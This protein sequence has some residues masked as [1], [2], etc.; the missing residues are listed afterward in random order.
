MRLDQNYTGVPPLV[1]R[2]L[3]S[4]AAWPTSSRTRT[5]SRS[6]FAF[7]ATSD[8]DL[9]DCL[10]EPPA[11]NC[12]GFF[13]VGSCMM[14][15]APGA[16]SEQ[17][18]E[19]IVNDQVGRSH[20][21]G[22]LATVDGR[23]RRKPDRS[24]A[25]EGDV[26]GR[27][28]RRD[29]SRR[30]RSRA[31]SRRSRPKTSPP[32]SGRSSGTVNSDCAAPAIETAG[33]TL[34]WRLQCRGQLDIDATGRVHLRQPASLH[35]GHHVEGQDGG[36]ADQ[37]REDRHRGRARRRLHAVR[38]RAAIRRCRD[39]GRLRSAAWCRRRSGRGRPAGSP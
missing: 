23:R 16:G 1:A 32:P 9:E 6:T 15:E 13:F 26:D 22:L 17:A 2:R 5:P 25:M 34:K 35:G 30:R 8:P 7:S 36:R 20:C 19:G 3:R 29:R 24:R 37:R 11:G 33:K 38:R 18:I 39:A 10:R 21:S 27:R 28:Q 14:P 31:A 12:R 4:R